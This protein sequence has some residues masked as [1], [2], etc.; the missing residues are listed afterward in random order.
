M[1]NSEI[2]QSDL[3]AIIE[4]YKGMAGGLLPLLHE[5]QE[6]QGYV[7]EQIVPMIADAMNLS[8]AEVHGV[9]SFYRHFENQPT[10]RHRIEICRA[11]ACQARGARQLEEHVRRKM[12]CDLNQTTRDKEFS[13][14]P[15]YC[16]GLCAT[17]PAISID[18]HPY[19]R[20]S[21]EKFDALIEQKR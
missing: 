14:R 15:V 17:G 16:L 20:V 18:E 5:I 13:L 10:G 11:E 4:H 7:P 8:R 21:C 9:I 6:R 19:S 2:K 3:K 1:A 12:A